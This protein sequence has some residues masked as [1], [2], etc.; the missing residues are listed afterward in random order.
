MIWV[1]IFQPTLRTLP[2]AHAANRR[3]WHWSM[4]KYELAESENG[5]VSSRN[6]W[7]KCANIMGYHCKILGFKLEYTRWT[8]YSLKVLKSDPG[9]SN[10]IL[11]Q[12]RPTNTRID[13]STITT[14]SEHSFVCTLNLRIYKKT[15]QWT[16][17]TLIRLQ[18]CAVCSGVVLV[19]HLIRPLLSAHTPKW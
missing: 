15:A 8:P 19:I 10:H 16:A 6:G 13:L 9:N 11:G 1:C 5:N 4:C 14:Y 12:F 18:F 7:M 2:G 3:N 17:Q